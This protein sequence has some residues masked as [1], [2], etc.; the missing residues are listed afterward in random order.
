MNVLTKKKNT[1]GRQV[2]LDAAVDAF[3]ELGYQAASVREIGRRSGVTQ[4]ALYHHFNSKDA[5]LLTIIDEFSEL[6]FMAVVASMSS[7]ENSVKRLKRALRR[8]F[9]FMKTHR[10]QLKI[11]FEDKSHLK[12]HAK[13]I[14]EDR[15]KSIFNLYRANLEELQRIGHISDIDLTVATFSIFGVLNWFY[16]WYQPDGPQSLEYLADQAMSF[17]FKGL[18]SEAGWRELDAAEQT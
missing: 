11:L 2:I 16:H 13:K 18:L 17:I 10:K 8:H 12:G 1:N 7:D 6:L 9:D 14:I 3:Y 15:E 5:I 4:A